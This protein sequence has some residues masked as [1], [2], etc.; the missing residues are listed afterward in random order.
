MPAQS[1]LCMAKGTR[2]ARRVLELW[3]D[4][5][6]SGN[7]NIPVHKRANALMG[8]KRHRGVRAG[9]WFWLCHQHMAPALA[10]RHSVAPCPTTREAACA[11]C[12][13]LKPQGSF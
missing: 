7:A 1:L 11:L 10:A 5:L 12:D 3:S 13:F 9:G 6:S 4:L 8:M 2:D